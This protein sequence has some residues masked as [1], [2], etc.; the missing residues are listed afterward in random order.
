MS[1]TFHPL[2][3]VNQPLSS[4]SSLNRFD[5]SFLFACRLF[6]SPVRLPPQTIMAEQAKAASPRSHHQTEANSGARRGRARLIESQTLHG[7]LGSSFWYMERA[8]C[9]V[10][11]GKY[12][13]LQ[14]T[15]SPL[16]W[17]WSLLMQHGAWCWMQ[18]EQLGGSLRN[19]PADYLQLCCELS[20]LNIHIFNQ[21]KGPSQ[22]N[23][24]SGERKNRG[25][26]TVIHITL[27][28]Q[29]NGKDVLQ[30][31]LGKICLDCDYGLWLCDLWDFVNH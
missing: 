10:L 29:L 19:R 14:M 13:I 27:V 22:R 25:A 9:S 26:R 6:V 28:S 7:P 23:R 24:Q 31:L 11:I 4:A 30:G 18:E 20:F 21:L 3:S 5:R 8:E 17:C 12:Q 16:Q 15:W 2:H 1:L